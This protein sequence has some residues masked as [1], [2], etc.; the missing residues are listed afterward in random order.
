LKFSLARQALILAAVSLVPGIGQAIYL[1]DKISWQ[2][3]IPPSQMVSV[4]QARQL[5]N[6]VIWV[7]ARPDVDFAR[8][9]VPGAISLN[10]DRW[11]ELLPQ[12]LTAWSPEKKVVVYC[13][14]Q[15]CDLARE[16]A[17]RLRKEAQLPDVFVLEGGWEGWLK[18]NR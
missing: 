18:K 13:S 9:H 14:A 2:S 12:L 15:S 6:A 3:P 4:D 16:V 10:E 11:S 1:R 8:D 5:G 17:E 7:D